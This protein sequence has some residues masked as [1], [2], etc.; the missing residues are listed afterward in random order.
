LI[1]GDGTMKL[2]KI[3]RKFE[4]KNIWH[5]KVDATG[6]KFFF[7]FGIL[8]VKCMCLMVGNYRLGGYRVWEGLAGR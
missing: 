5:L 1:A 3:V 2:L 8:G 4:K 7:R 6:C